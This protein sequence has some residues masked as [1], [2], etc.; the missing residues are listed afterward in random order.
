[1]SVMQPVQTME[2][3]L[4]PLGARSSTRSLT[5]VVSRSQSEYSQ[6]KPFQ[7][8]RPWRRKYVSRW[9][10]DWKDC[11]QLKVQNWR[12]RLMRWRFVSD[13]D[14]W[15]RAV[16]SDGFLCICQLK[17]TATVG[18]QCKAVHRSGGMECHD[19]MSRLD[20]RNGRC[21]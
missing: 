13:D 21:A 7:T 16:K 14:S 18:L 10:S 9:C 20:M 4:G 1:M 5:E 6:A 12:R 19:T 8:R 3:A 11:K 15:R 2:R 17:L